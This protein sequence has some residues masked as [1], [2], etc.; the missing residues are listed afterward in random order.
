MQ[1]KEKDSRFSSRMMSLLLGIVAASALVSLLSTD[2]VERVLVSPVA[3]IGS[4]LS[5]ELSHNS[6]IAF[7]AQLG[8]L[9][10]PLILVAL[11]AITFFAIRSAKTRD[12]QIGFGLI[13]GGGLANV[14]DRLIDGTVTDF[15]RVLEF[16]VFNVAD[17]LITFGVVLVVL[18]S[19]WRRK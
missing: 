2:I 9:Q 7:G 17:T 11:I 3:I 14:I 10:L 4:I 15:I 18:E 5:F 16:P 1:L 19:V 12:S 8:V 6:G 13:I